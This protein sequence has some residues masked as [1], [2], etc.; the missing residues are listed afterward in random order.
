MVLA[1]RAHMELAQVGVRQNCPVK[2]THNTKRG[3]HGVQLPPA[4]HVPA[5]APRLAAAR[6]PG[7]GRVDHFRVC[8]LP[9]SALGANH[10]LQRPS[11]HR[12][13]GL[14]AGEGL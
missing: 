8:H 5:G 2:D 9:R 6:A 4:H 1:E 7:G 3:P 14:R 10:A 13:A 12:E 11:R